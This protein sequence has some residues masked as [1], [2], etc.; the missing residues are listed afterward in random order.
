MSNIEIAVLGGGCFW[1]TEAVFKHLKGVLSVMP[2]YAGG[3]LENPT[4]RQ[5]CTGKTG[6]AEVARIEFDPSQISYSDLLEVF[7]YTHDPTS[8]DRQGNDVGPQYHSIILHNN[9]QQKQVAEQIL[10]ELDA[11]GA[12]QKAIVTELK[13]LSAFYT[14][15]DY[16]RD[17]YN[18]NQFQP[19]CMVVIT[20]KLKKFKEKYQ[21]LL[22]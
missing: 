19:Y 3:D 2:G 18:N 22:K 10:K 9:E 7:F 11:S 5:V 8:L 1:C 6:H 15:E 20:P 13:A 12:Y 14:A 4:Y 16:H 21:S 17:Y